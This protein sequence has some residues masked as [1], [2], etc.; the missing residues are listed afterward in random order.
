MLSDGISP[1]DYPANSAYTS[2]QVRGTF[3]LGGINGHMSRASL[4][5]EPVY[6][7]REAR[8]VY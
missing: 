2:L 6:A 7:F 1:V 3:V 5:L 8:T 4:L